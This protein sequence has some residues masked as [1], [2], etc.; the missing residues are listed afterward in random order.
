MTTVS[1]VNNLF[2]LLIPSPL[3]PIG[4]RPTNEIPTCYDIFHSCM[5]KDCCRVASNTHSSVSLSSCCTTSLEPS[6][7]PGGLTASRYQSGT[8]SFYQLLLLVT[9]NVSD[10][11]RP[12]SLGE[13]EGVLSMEDGLEVSVAPHL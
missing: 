9:I 13:V 2:Y 4:L 10:L 5:W 7:F 1:D 11:M 8:E 3:F 12:S 6:E